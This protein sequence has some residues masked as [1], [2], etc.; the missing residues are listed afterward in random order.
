MKNNRLNSIVT[1]HKNFQKKYQKVLGRK[2]YICKTEP[3]EN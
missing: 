1:K 3:N 2:N